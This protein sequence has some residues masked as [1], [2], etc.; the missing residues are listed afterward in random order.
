MSCKTKKCGCADVGLTTPTPCVHDTFSCP[1]PDPC[2]ETF[3]ACCT[4]YNRDTI[5]DIDLKNG[6]NLCKAM[7]LIT[8]WLTNPL[9]I[10]PNATCKSVVNFFSTTITSSTIGLGWVANG[11]PDTYQIEYKEAAAV[12]WTLNTSVSNTT[13]AD[14][15]G[16]LTANTAYHIRLKSTCN[17]TICYSVT[18]EVKTKPTT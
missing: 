17:A 8:L 4:I 14:A 3:S 18:I 2:P 10:Q 11:T 1:N 6:D 9:C 15:I 7:Q 12:S 16:G 13:F 5:V